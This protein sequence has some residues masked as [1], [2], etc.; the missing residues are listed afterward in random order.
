MPQTCSKAVLI[1]GITPL[2]QR[3]ARGDFPTPMSNF[4]F[5]ELKKGYWNGRKGIGR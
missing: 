4:G 2:W 5:F 1:W 3:G